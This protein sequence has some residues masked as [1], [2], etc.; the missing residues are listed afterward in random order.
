MHNPVMM[1]WVRRDLA[2]LAF[3]AAAVVLALL[4]WA[5]YDANLQMGGS[6]RSVSHTLEVI[7][8]LDRINV[9]LRDAEI[10]HRGFLIAPSG[11]LQSK[12]DL[13]LKETRVAI[14]QAQALT[15]DNPGAQ[16]HGTRIAELFATSAM[17]MRKNT[18]QGSSQGQ[19]AATA[20]LGDH[21]QERIRGQIFA[22]VEAMR[23][24]ELRL[25]QMRRERVAKSYTSTSILVLVVVLLSL[26]VVG[27]LGSAAQ[28]RRL[29]RASQYARSLIEASLDPLVTI[30]AEGKITDVNA[31]TMN[32]TGFG[33]DHLIGTDFSNYF[34]EPDK[35]RAGYKQVFAEGSVTDYP[36]TIRH[37]DGQ[38]ADVL[39]NAS[40]Y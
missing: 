24:D 5:L 21:S 39:Y 37:A 16:K 31:A 23:R 3:G 26:L 22:L 28:T 17:V 6:V 35:A 12:R 1:S 25:L 34:T 8:S 33:R 29:A 4:V 7:H 10:A 18:I 27:Y 40:V 2:Q 9:G 36:L 20:Y 13:A 15:H 11:V 38:L 30:S 19:A 32:A 14:A